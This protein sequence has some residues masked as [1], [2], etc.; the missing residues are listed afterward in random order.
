M[1]GFELISSQQSLTL[2]GN[3]KRVCVIER[4]SKNVTKL[5]FVY[6]YLRKILHLLAHQGVT[7]ELYW[8]EFA[9]TGPH[10]FFKNCKKSGRH[11]GP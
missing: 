6:N 7:P 9:Q 3:L 1:C 10:E 2:L 4:L 8:L 11:R 5:P